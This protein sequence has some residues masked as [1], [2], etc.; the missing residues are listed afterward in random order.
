MKYEIFI[1]YRRCDSQ[2]SAIILHEKL[3][4]E[5]NTFLDCEGIGKGDCWPDTIEH[6]LKES[7]VVLVLI[8]K[9]WNIERLN[10]ED[11]WVLREI[12]LA[13]MEGKEII[14]I[15]VDGAGM[16]TADQLPQTIR[17]LPRFQGSRMTDYGS[18]VDELIRDIKNIQLG[19]AF[20]VEARDFSEFCNRRYAF[21]KIL[22]D[23][24]AYVVYL[25]VDTQL[26][27]KVIIRLFKE[28]N[29]LSQFKE[30]VLQATR[31][32]G[33]VSNCVAIH[34]ADF[35]RFPHVVLGYME[36]GSLRRKLRKTPNGLGHK[37]V[38]NILKYIGNSLSQA[39]TYHG[40]LK[41]SNI[42]LNQDGIPF[43]N[44]L[45]T[46]G[47]ITR[48]EILSGLSDSGSSDN[49]FESSREEDLRY[50][51]PE[52]LDTTYKGFST[53]DGL[54]KV[55]QYML[56]LMGYELLT[57][58]PPKTF[59]A[60]DELTSVPSNKTLRERL[61]RLE[62]CP[63]ESLSEILSKMT[64]PDPELRYNK[65]DTVVDEINRSMVEPVDVEI[66][67]GSYLR[68]LHNQ[69]SGKSFFET[70]YS[71]FIKDED[72]RKIFDRFDLKETDKDSMKQQYSHLQGAIF[73]LIE[74]ANEMLSGKPPEEV[75]FLKHAAERHG[76]GDGKR[77]NSHYFIAAR[78][79]HFNDFLKILLAIIC[80]DKA[81]GLDPYDEYC[82]K[83]EKDKQRINQAWKKVLNPGIHYMKDQT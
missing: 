33:K 25:A 73:G 65:L 70:F 64:S 22:S 80:G 32:A 1:S 8:G 30:E 29:D 35:D 62:N 69:V 67:R 83:S 37:Q 11:D 3:R 16:P 14:P 18:K 26:N 43:F 56:G 82:R 40:N 68:C 38:S 9:E 47:E 34:D 6:T 61:G 66:V 7:S 45:N 54:E 12:D 60:V 44:P 58:T 79:K 20:G 42:L 49:A 23:K 17:N 15:L 71:E 55:D 77:E 36:G 72:I 78:P 27:R 13:M 46:T 10:N 50:L 19:N 2:Q 21:K 28:N 41:P 51:A 52:R 39:K 76:R 5:F 74:F 81:L 57:G 53:T 75:S 63:D 4:R 59:L 31:F 48:T 24:K